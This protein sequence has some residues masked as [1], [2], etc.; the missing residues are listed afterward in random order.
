[1][2]FIFRDGKPSHAHTLMQI[3]NPST[4]TKPSKPSTEGE[5]KKTK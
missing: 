4:F 5:K 2:C 3:L 1:M